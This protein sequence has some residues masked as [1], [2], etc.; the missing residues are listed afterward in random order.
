MA[1]PAAPW[2]V[3]LNPGSCFLGDGSEPPPRRPSLYACAR[4]AT[5][6]PCSSTRRDSRRR[7]C[8]LPPYDP[9][10]RMDGGPY[11]GAARPARRRSPTVTQPVSLGWQPQRLSCSRLAQMSIGSGGNASYPSRMAV[12]MVEQLLPWRAWRPQLWRVSS[13]GNSAPRRRPSTTVSP[14]SF[15]MALTMAWRQAPSVVQACSY[16]FDLIFV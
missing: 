13:R 3:L 1:P 12:P 9:V 8:G 6:A 14:S 15:P 10:F 4:P 2:L 16:L 11:G 7:R 5:S